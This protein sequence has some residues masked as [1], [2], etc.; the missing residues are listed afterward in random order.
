MTKLSERLAKRWC[1]IHIL[2]VVAGFLILVYFDLIL[3]VMHGSLKIFMSF[4]GIALVTI[5]NIGLIIN[6]LDHKNSKRRKI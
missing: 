5:G 2:L 4:I 1:A 6:I 3:E